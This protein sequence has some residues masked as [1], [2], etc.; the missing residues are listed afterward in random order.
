MNLLTSTI[1]LTCLVTQASASTPISEI[2]KR[3]TDGRLT[4]VVCFGDSITGA[5]YHTGGQRA[6]CDMLGLALQ[7]ANPNANLQMVNAGI[8]GHTTVNALARIKKDVIAKKPHLVVVMF[9]MND[10][11]RVPLATYAKNMREIVE[12]CQDAGAAVVLCTP[13]GVSPN[14]ARPEKKLEQYAESVRT[15]AK[16]YS[17]PLVDCLH[18]WQAFRSEDPVGWSLVMSDAIHPNMNGHRRFAELMVKS[19]CGQ[20]VSLDD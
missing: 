6:W 18:D 10:V 11:A 2:N 12:Q 19:I 5:Y 15:I 4:K 13:N 16:E 7:K 3:L 8:S 1:F 20:D 14:G 17:L 9:G